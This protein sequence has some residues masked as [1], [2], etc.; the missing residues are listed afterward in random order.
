MLASGRSDR[1]LVGGARRG[2]RRGSVELV[3]PRIFGPKRLLCHLAVL[4]VFMVCLRLGWWQWQRS[5][6]LGG[7]AQN[8]S[9]ALLWPVFGGYAVFVW[10]RLLRMEIRG[11]R[12]RQGSGDPV[13][14]RPDGD[15]GHGV[16]GPSTALVPY[17]AP[18]PE[19][20]A[21]NAYLTQLNEDAKA[22][23]AAKEGARHVG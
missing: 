12:A 14:G 2:S 16:N 19:L 6:A 20:V 15:G 10:V 11:D 1:R 21:Y 23:Q 8:L 3:D 7:A 13:L 4:V 18:D 9:Y 17:V 22:K 5:Q